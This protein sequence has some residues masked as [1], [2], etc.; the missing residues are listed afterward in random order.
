MKVPEFSQLR[1]VAVLLYFINI[2]VL[3]ADTL[4]LKSRTIGTGG[5]PTPTQVG[6]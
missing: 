1:P 2:S 4:A 6:V 3:V 5:D